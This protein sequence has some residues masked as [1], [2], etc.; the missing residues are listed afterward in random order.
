MSST[1]S[2]RKHS[3]S[4]SLEEILG[5]I[6]KETVTVSGHKGYF[7]GRSDLERLKVRAQA[8]KDL[9]FPTFDEQGQIAKLDKAILELE[10]ENDKSSRMLENFKASLGASKDELA[11]KSAEVDSLKAQIQAKSNEHK[12]ESESLKKSLNDWTAY[13][14]SLKGQIA[15]GSAMP[16]SEEEKT[17]QEELKAT[18]ASI[19]SL[20]ADLH[21]VKSEREKAQDS[22]NTAL[23]DLVSAKAAVKLNHERVGGLEAALAKANA[24]VPITEVKSILQGIKLDSNLEKMVG[25]RA[26]EWLQKLQSSAEEGLKSDLYKIVVAT[27]VSS[28]KQVSKLS[29]LL[30]QLLQWAKTVSYRSREIIRPWL[31]S[32]MNDIYSGKIKTMEYYAKT[33]ES[34]VKEHKFQKEK[35]NKSKG[36]LLNADVPL[37]ESGLIWA[38][39]LLINRPKS[40]FKRGLGWVA[41]K[42]KSLRLYISHKWNSFLSFWKKKQVRKPVYTEDIYSEIELRDEEE[43]LLKVDPEPLDGFKQVEKG[44]GKEPVR[45]HGGLG[46]RMG[47]NPFASRLPPTGRP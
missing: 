17:L 38:R 35:R 30:E 16:G 3:H 25:K 8:L 28:N 22:L 6:S 46:A 39:I 7:V 34:V 43:Q 14:K 9:E 44:K 23:K 47:F 40:L 26:F 10:S 32:L 12:T 19:S 1:T 13:A 27:K 15:K 36:L 11:A 31:N 29:W 20:Q 45:K 24:Q 18:N 21:A 5:K 41:T 42:S 37:W 4:K 33:L 2:E